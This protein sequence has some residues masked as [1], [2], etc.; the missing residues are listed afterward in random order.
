MEPRLRS[1][2]RSSPLVGRAGFDVEVCDDVRRAV[3]GAD[4][5]CTVTASTEPLLHGDWVDDGTHVNAVGAYQAHAR[6]LDAAL[7]AR[8]CSLRG[9][10]PPQRACRRR[11][12]A[13]CDAATASYPKT[14]SPRSSAR[15]SSAS[16][17]AAPD[18]G[19]VTVFES[20]GLAIQDVAAAAAIQD[21]AAKNGVGTE[22]AFP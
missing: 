4:I 7:V 10:Q 14:S 9:R 12:P 19:A 3:Q 5:V 2:R 22:I 13:A 1:E 6:E 8:A 16:V 17:P 18:E 11:G 20:L 21:Y 15:F